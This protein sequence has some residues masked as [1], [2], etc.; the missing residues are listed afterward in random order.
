LVDTPEIG[1]SGYLEAIN[2]VQSICGVGT[3]ALVDEDDGQIGGSFGR[4][5]GVVYCG[6]YFVS[7]NELQGGYFVSLNE[8]QGG[9]AVI[10][11]RYCSKSEFSMTLWDLQFGCAQQQDG[12]DPSYP[13]VCIPRYPPPDL[14]CGDILYRNIRVLP[15]DPHLF[16]S[17]ADGIGCEM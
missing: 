6:G 17:D 1:Q 15:T 3:E 8:L 9:Y 12:C 10:D 7:L 14:N 16:D 13:D 11:Q 2:F 5:I 4:L